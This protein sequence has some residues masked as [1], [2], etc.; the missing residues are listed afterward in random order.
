VI[1][2]LWLF[3]VIAGI[4]GV[5]LVMALG[6]ARLRAI[7]DCGVGRLTGL[8]TPRVIYLKSKGGGDV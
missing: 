4:G 2:G 6:G 5:S 7:E 1:P 3:V 8:L